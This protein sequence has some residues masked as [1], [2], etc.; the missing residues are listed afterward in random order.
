MKKNLLILC[1]IAILSFNGCNND[2]KTNITTQDSIKESI[3]NTTIENNT[4]TSENNITSNFTYLD[5]ISG[6][7]KECA[8][9]TYSPYYELL[10]FKITNYYERIA[11]NTAEV[12]L[13]YTIIH[14]NYDK[15]P[16]TVPYIKEAKENKNP[17][18]EVYYEEY[19]KP[20][21]MNMEL[22]IVIDEK[23]EITLYMDNNPHQE[24]EWVIFKMEDIIIK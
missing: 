10:D 5:K 21:E 16:D 20:Q 14:K 17:N 7:L 6:Y 15:D 19:L 11:D 22:R 2:S 23:D 24:R 1:F 12:I 3:E 18:Y 4:K 9:T 8:E 13:N